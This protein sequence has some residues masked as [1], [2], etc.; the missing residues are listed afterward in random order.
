LT[1]FKFNPSKKSCGSLDLQIP[2]QHRTSFTNLAIQHVGHQY[3]LV[4]NAQLAVLIVPRSKCKPQTLDH[5]H[6][7]GCLVEGDLLGPERWDVLGR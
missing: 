5:K 6:A 7:F 4:P 3:C 1:G 2:D